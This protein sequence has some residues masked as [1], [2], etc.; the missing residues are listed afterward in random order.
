MYRDKPRWRTGA[1][2]WQRRRILRFV[3]EFGR[4]EGYS[5]S[6]REI[7]EE[8][9][10]AVST[11]AY[12]VSV[13]EQEGALHRGAGQPRTIVE[14]V[15]PATR[16]EGDAVEVPLIGQIAAGIPLDA[17]ELAEETFLMPRRL[18]GRGTLF[19]LR[20]MGDSMTGAAITDGD[21]VV[22]RQQ[23]AAENGEIVAAQLD[24]SGTAE[25]TVKT[26]QR[27]EGH[28]WLMPHNPAYQPIPADDAIILGK[29]V[30]VVR[31][32]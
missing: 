25:A 2:D 10:L 6:Y 12:H 29:V 5:P 17:V 24:R 22:V 20:V 28:V 11:V 31:P 19:M 21:L 9:G 23:Q 13:L 14:P 26:L 8:L 3:Q 1:G 16:A 27:L 18:V 32:A 4:R 15:D 7:A 30:A